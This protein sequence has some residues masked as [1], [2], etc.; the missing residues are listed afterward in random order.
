MLEHVHVCVCVRMCVCLHRQ[1][2]A[3]IAVVWQCLNKCIASCASMC[4]RLSHR[5]WNK[6]EIW[7]PTEK[8]S[9]R[10]KDKGIQCFLSLG[11]K[12]LGVIEE[13]HC[14]N[15]CVITESQRKQW[16]SLCLF[17]SQK[18]LGQL[19]SLSNCASTESVCVRVD[20]CL[21]IES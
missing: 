10:E 14:V 15:L 11:P 21:K 3:I 12:P 1:C 16:Y 7:W 20:V 13:F 8:D 17:T 4:V 9:E 6:G 18:A 2:L 5:Q 19:V